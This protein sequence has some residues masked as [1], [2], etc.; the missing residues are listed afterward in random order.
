ME[1]F[2]DT[3]HC[4]IA[5]LSFFS[6]C[7]LDEATSLRLDC[8]WEFTEYTFERWNSIYSWSRS[9]VRIWT[10]PDFDTLRW[11]TAGHL[12]YDFA[13]LR[14]F[15]IKDLVRC[16]L[17]KSY[18]HICTL[19]AFKQIWFASARGGVLFRMQHYS[20]LHSLSVPRCVFRVLQHNSQIA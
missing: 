3:W 12:T 10:C 6:D 16:S 8:F 5:L 17:H 11:E 19:K 2:W 13:S 9:A 15:C 18:L 7:N 20:K 14:F 1:R 4:F